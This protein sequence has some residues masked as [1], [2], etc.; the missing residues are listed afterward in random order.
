MKRYVNLFERYVRENEE[1][2]QFGD[3]EYMPNDDMPTDDMPTD[4]DMSNGDMSKAE[5][6]EKIAEFFKTEVFAD[7][8]TKEKSILAKVG[9][10]VAPEINEHC[11]NEGLR[12]RFKSFKEKTMIGAGLSTLV[13]GFIGFVSQVTGWSDSEIMTGLHEF[14][15]K[16]GFDTYTG[17]ITVGM[18]F[19][20]LL[21]ALKGYS[22]RGNRLNTPYTKGKPGTGFNSY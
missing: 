4:D 13:T 21:L 1:I 9:A 2:E 19:A 3:S 18:I 7:I 22:D 16:F 12:D 6:I 20:G 11:L 10:E 5:I 17:P 8:T 15:L 14:F